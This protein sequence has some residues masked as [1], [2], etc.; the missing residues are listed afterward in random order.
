MSKRFVSIWFRSLATDWCCRRQSSLKELPFVLAVP[1]HGRKVITAVNALAAGQGINIGMV[2]ADAKALYPSLQVLDDQPEQVAKALHALAEWCI[3]FTPCVA[4]DLPDGLILDATGCAHLWGGEDKYLSDISSRLKA[5]GYQTQLAI[6]DTIGA[7]WGFARYGKA[8]IIESGVHVTALLDLPAQ[9]LRLERDT[10]E[11]LF[12]LGLHY[13][14]DF[15]SMPRSALRRRFGDG[16]LTRSDQAFGT[17]AE[18]LQPVQP[19][20]PWQERLPCFDP[21]VTATGIGIAV[22][23]LLDGLCKRLQH[24][25]KGLRKALLNAYRVDGKVEKVEIGTNRASHNPE[26]LFKLF[27]HKLSSIEPAL[28]IELF[29][30][31]AKQVEDVEPLQAAL[32]HSSFG[33][34][35]NN[36][37]ELL[38]R[39]GGKLGTACIKRYVPAEHYWPERC[40][41]PAASLEE[42]PATSWYMDRPRPLELLPQPEPITVTAPIPDYPPMFFQYKGKMH[43][44]K[45]A[46]G[47]ERIEQEWWLQN[48][49]HRDYYVVEDEEGKRYW[50][51]RLGHYDAQKTYGWY[52]HGFFA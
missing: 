36:I 42:Q 48:G 9:A 52:L 24:E 27:E 41:K 38:D 25:G 43:K 32:W 1:D 30:L 5:F 22:Q 35:N 28:G 2:V 10:V 40:F 7:A 45:K 11:Q 51:F 13:V 39:I 21:I 14:R 29:V 18:I 37:A 6:A 17:K 31:E 3:R 44:V 49:Q 20:E 19:V 15:S 23:R 46:D 4:V 16:M 34:D 12:H 50:L 47:P 8:S 26:H 33:L